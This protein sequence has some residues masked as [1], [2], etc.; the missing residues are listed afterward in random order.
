M[1]PAVPDRAY[2]LLHGFSHHRPPE[3]WQYWLAHR[4]RDRGERAYYPG[5]PFEDSP[6]L[7]EWKEALRW[8]LRQIADAGER[9][10]ICN[11]VAGMLWMAFAAD[12]PPE[13]EPVDRL[14]MVSPPDPAKIPEAAA[15]FRVEVDGPAVQASVRSPI[16]IANSESDPYN[17]TGGGEMYGPALGAELDL[18]EGGAHIGGGDGYGPW[19]SVEAWCEDP[20]TRLVPNR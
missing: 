3:H 15:S 16:R 17:P 10:V 19:P 8:S 13:F 11:S 12:P 4:L 6:R 1:V 20:A 9:V 14:L 5:L 7:E 2:L 18:I